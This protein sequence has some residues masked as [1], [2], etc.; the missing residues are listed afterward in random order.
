MS[1]WYRAY[2]GTVRDDKLAECA[3]IAGAS[4]AVVIATWHAILESAADTGD[5]GRFETNPRRVAAILAEPVA[6][7]DA[8]FKAMDEI[9]LIGNDLVTAWRKRQY[10]SD[11]S[12]ERSR[13]HRDMKRNAGATAMQR[14]A[15][16]PDT[17]AE[18]ETDISSSLRSD[19]TRERRVSSP[20]P[21]KHGTTEA[22]PP[23]PISPDLIRDWRAVR[24]AKRA[25]PLS[26]TAWAAM[27]RE[28][29]KAGITLE[30]AVR[31]CVERGW[32]S[33]RADWLADKREARAPPRKGGN[34]FVSVLRDLQGAFDDEHHH[35]EPDDL[36]RVDFDQLGQDF[37]DPR[38]G[39]RQS[40]DVLDL[41]PLDHG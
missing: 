16:P 6:I 2:A 4:R 20:S 30:A 35:H 11:S 39:R 19:D 1:R 15:T 36:S 29:D 33:L 26:N 34:G 32:Q 18:T 3:V 21:A 7:V 5:G 37:A 14:C 40:S 17:E 23:T 38:T 25:G 31:V 28:A 8:V 9:G 24:K 22:P 13:K 27:T 41:T 12:T 10:E